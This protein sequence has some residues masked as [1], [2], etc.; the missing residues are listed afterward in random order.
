M[1]FEPV[2]PSYQ[3]Y[4][5]DE[6]HLQGRA[7]EICFPETGEQVALAFAHGA[8][9]G[10]KVT[11]QGGRTG[12]SGGA[13]PEGG[14]ILNLSHLLKVGSLQRQA[15]GSGILEAEAGVTLETV[16]SRSAPLRF[17]PNPTET[18]ATLGG[19]FA[20]GAAGP[21]G[22]R[23]GAMSSWVEALTWVT[24]E[25]KIWKIPRGAYVSRDGFLPLPDGS[26]LPG[27]DQ[28]DLIDFLSGWGGRMGA[29]V[30]FRLRLQP[31]APDTWGLVFFFD[32]EEQCLRF[33][34][35]LGREGLPEALTAAEYLNGTALHL[36][37][38]HRDRPG[39]RD[40][41][42]L[43]G[44]A[45]ICLE[46]EGSP[47]ET[48]QTLGRLLD[49]FEENGGREENSWADQ[50]PAML[51]RFRNLRHC[52]QEILGE[53]PEIRREDGSLYS[54]DLQVPR[55]SELLPRL[56]EAAE[57]TGIPAAIYGHVLDPKLHMVLLPTTEARGAACG[58]CL[59]AAAGWT[60]RLGGSLWG[61]YGMGRLHRELC[62]RRHDEKAGK[63]EKIARVLDPAQRLQ[64]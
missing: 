29:A 54:L 52:L 30:S 39:L 15:D 34:E 5:Q 26:Q 47:R 14:L 17:L 55:F 56:Q 53:L 62:T 7:E 60:A 61:E 51:R 25:G 13:V 32:R 44:E 50:S 38:A 4:L 10:Q 6:S 12:L 40:L 1:K 46:T 16:Q 59:E 20:C 37:N 36:L 41:G 23:W 64:L 49:L 2:M 27:E 18:T 58:T 8:E 9:R 3:S 11:I 19:M 33:A 63:Q 45:A 21:G 35:G 22:F 24:P 57:E 42:Q 43:P 31:A 28:T 48:E